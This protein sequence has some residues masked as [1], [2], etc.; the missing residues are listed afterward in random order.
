MTTPKQPLVAEPLL[1]DIEQLIEQSRQKVASYANQTLTLLHWHIGQR[2]QQALLTDGRAEYGQ[3]IVATLSQQLT[4]RYGKGFTRSAL[5]R[6]I[7]FASLFPDQKKVA[8]LS[9][10]LSWSHWVLILPLDEAIKRDFYAQLCAAERWSVRQFKER[11]NAMLYERTALSKQPEQLIEQELST[12]QQEQALNPNLLLKDPYVLDFL[13]LQ[14]RYMEKDLEDA[15]LREM[16]HF[17]L[18]LGMGFT[19]MARQKRIDVGQK[20]Y[21]I[22]L[23]FYNRKLRRLVAI[24]LKLGNFQPEYKGQMELYLRWLA[25]HEQQADE[26][27]PLGII[28]CAGKEQEEIELLELDQSSIHVAQYL[29]ELPS[30]ELL[31]QQLHRAIAAAKARLDGDAE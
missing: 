1:T 29:T 2:I 12:L 31:T 27:A 30:P 20:D 13:G 9:H 4:Q 19:F 18:E 25:K 3:Q 28:L 24:D 10:Q 15:I 16:E 7:K 6:M 8:T 23:L 14:D 21:Y 5:N 26:Q 11:I 17:L 22:D